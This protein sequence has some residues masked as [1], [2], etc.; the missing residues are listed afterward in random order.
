MH[1]I[2][3]KDKKINF[4]LTRKRVKNINLRVKPNQEVLVSANKDVPLDYIKKFVSSKA[5]WIDK[6]LEDFKKKG[7]IKKVEKEYVN[8]EFFMYLGRKYKLKVFKSK[9]ERVKYFK[10]YIHLYTADL[11]D[12][13]QKEKLMDNWYKE[14]SKVIIKDS[15]NR[16]YDLVKPYGIE[17]PE[18]GIRKMKFRWGTCY[19]ERKKII[20]NRTLIK[21]PKDCIDYV[22]LHELVHFKHKNHGKDF[23][24]TLDILMPDWQDRKKLL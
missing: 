13:N 1:S 19:T 12:F 11:D 23:Y 22:V 21:T 3:Y 20:I 18:L 10:G 24:K 5:G 17:Y 8:G 14:R 15:L 2:Y 9:E 6:H 4:T 16:I 7:G